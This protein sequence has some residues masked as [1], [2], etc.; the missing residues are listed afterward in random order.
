MGGEHKG[1]RMVK[2][3]RH[4]GVVAALLVLNSSG[5]STANSGYPGYMPWQ[6]PPEQRNYAP[7]NQ[8]ST[9]TPSQS[10]SQR[11]YPQGYGYP[12]AWPGYAQPYNQSPY[13]QTPVLQPPPQAPQAEAASLQPISL[14]SRKTCCCTCN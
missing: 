12:Q 1:E 11:A 13:T 5:A 9:G 7:P 8:R 14:R 4:L 10:P 3:T 2:L 6:A